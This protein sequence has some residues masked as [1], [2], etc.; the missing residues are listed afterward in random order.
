M[1]AG[2]RVNSARD[3]DGMS[4]CKLLDLLRALEYRLRRSRERF[5]LVFYY[6]FTEST[7]ASRSHPGLHLHDK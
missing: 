4:Q 2:L 1:K 5:V 6:G 7:S 3:A